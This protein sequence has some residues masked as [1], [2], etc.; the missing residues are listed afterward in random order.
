MGT[1]NDLKG[2]TF[3]KLTVLRRGKN[4]GEKIGWVCRCTC[5][6]ETLVSAWSLAGGKT[7]SCGAWVCR[8]GT[9]EEQTAR[10]K[11]NLK[12]HQRRYSIMALYGLP[13]E[14]YQ[15]MLKRQ[16]GKCAI[17]GEMMGKPNVDH[18][19]KTGRTR[20]LL[21]L[22]CNHLLGNAKDNVEILKKAIRY[23]RRH[24]GRLQHRNGN[25]SGE[26]GRSGR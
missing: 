2:K 4:K 20:D 6:R 8:W 15:D 5:G 13:W 22:F 17:C 9:K 3:G 24:S 1:F 12:L 23:L 21:C 19:H 18:S 7:S 26:R 10:R 11:K 25:G 14:D 16:G